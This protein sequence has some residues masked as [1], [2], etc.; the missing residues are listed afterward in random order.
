MALTL[1]Q[2]LEMLKKN[3]E[4]LKKS[5]ALHSDL[6]KLLREDVIN[7][8]EIEAAIQAELDVLNVTLLEIDERMDVVCKTLC[9]KQSK[10]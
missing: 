8:K 2:E 3:E 7:K 5:R 4:V 6:L 1:E 10:L 9:D